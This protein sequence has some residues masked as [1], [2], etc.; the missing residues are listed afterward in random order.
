MK[1][2]L[3]LLIMGFTLF[4]QII[5][6]QVPSYVPSNGLVGYWPFNG[7]ANDASGNG[8]NGVVNGASLSNDRF[9]IS[10]NA[11]QFTSNPQNITITNLHQN[12]ILNY[13][14]AGW[15]QIQQQNGGGTVI[16]GNMP[17]SSP[18]GLRF[19]LGVTNNFQW[20]V[21]DGMNT[22]GI[23]NNNLNAVNYNDNSWH[24]FA[25][26][27]S[28]N[29]GLINASSFKVYTD[30][31][32]MSSVT[33]QDHWPSGSG[34]SMGFNVFAP[35][36]NGTLP[37]VIGNH[38]GFAEFFNGKLDDIGIWNRALTQ[39]EITNLYLADTACQSLV[40]N[41]GIL[42]FN[43]IRYNNT[44]TIYPNPANDHI[45]IDCG[46]LANVTGYQ[47]KIVNTIGQEV[48][49]GAMNTQQFV[50]PLNT[51]GGAGVYF[52]K[53]YDAS[54]NLLNTKKIVLQ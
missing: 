19:A 27:F 14:V 38:N 32:L 31:I 21:E 6:A 22:N 2:K 23:V 1:N 3:L 45:T 36:D 13:S 51:W 44:V 47:I 8:F 29:P 9:G 28:S 54:N 5:N 39:E 37:V 11:Y 12:N 24:S 18:S 17:L 15:F 48:F 40:I 35:V 20:N 33:F 16:A 42:S 49:S 4:T 10:N 34:F 26:T 25:V 41:T 7:N 53:I 30:G 46:N 52:V 50:V 43:P